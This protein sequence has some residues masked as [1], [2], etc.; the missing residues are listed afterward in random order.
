MPYIEFGGVSLDTKVLTTSFACDLTACRGACCT[1]PG[2]RGAPVREDEVAIMH[3]ASTA[4]RFMLSPAHQEIL[5]ARGPLEG[6]AGDRTTVCVDGA[7]CVFVTD[8]AGIA[9]CSI[10]RLYHQ[11]RF[12]WR[13]PISCHLYPIR[14]DGG[15]PDRLRYEE[16]SI[17]RAARERG[18]REG[19]RLTDFLGEALERAFGADWTA[20]ARSAAAEGP[21]RT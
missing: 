4:V 2:G 20:S 13:K 8:D 16:S 21:K 15:T 9:V 5:D 12:P 14:I 17:C 10:E 6:P 11:G 3:E 1:I 19:I 7:A 18:E